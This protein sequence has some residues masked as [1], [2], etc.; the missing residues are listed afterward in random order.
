MSMEKRRT[1]KSKR[2]VTQKELLRYIDDLG[3]YFL[4]LS[5][6]QGYRML[7]RGLP[8]LDF[9]FP[10][11]IEKAANQLERQGLV[12]KQ[13]TKEGI[14]VKISNKGKIQILKYN[15]LELKPPKEKWDGKWRL[16]FFDVVELERNK[17]DALRRYLRQIGMEQFQESIFVSPFNIFDQLQYIR[18]I[19]DIPH[20]V[21]MAR[22]DWIENE[23]ELKEIFEIK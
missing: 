23:T 7:K 18:E 8:N 3:D 4:P 20:A 12:E 16:V 14:S 13:S 11:S 15:L 6:S 2:R 9:Y 19:L 22:L 17:R 1:T 10:Y 5:K 21:K